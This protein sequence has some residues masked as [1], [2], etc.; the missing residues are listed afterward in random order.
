VVS[1][2]PLMTLN[3]WLQAN[4][5]KGTWLARQVGVDKSA[6]SRM[7]KGQL[8]PSLR[9]AIAIEQATNGNVRVAEL[10]QVAS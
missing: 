6:I 10:A 2:Y 7:R 5:R 8:T 1:N 4:P 9:V 3:E